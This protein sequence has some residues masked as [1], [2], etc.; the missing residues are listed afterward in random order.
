M[1][2]YQTVVLVFPNWWTDLPMPVYSFFD[3]YD[4]TEKNIVVFC[5]HGGSG[6]SDTVSTVKELEPKAV[7]MEGLA[8][9][10]DDVE[11]SEDKVI[12]K[13]EKL[14]IGK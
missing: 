4:L 11:D 5:T 13:V 6:F 2:S 14:G 9:Y 10:H 8:V 7:V 1:G 3:E 12:E